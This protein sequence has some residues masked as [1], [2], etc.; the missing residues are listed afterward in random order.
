MT[1]VLNLHGHEVI[2]NKNKGK[3]VIEIDLG[4][5]T[6][7]CL[8]IDIFSVD[9][10]EYIA[11]L[12]GESSD[13][14]IFNYTDIYDSEDIDLSMIEDDDEMDEVYHLFSHYW[15]DEMIDDLI[16]EYNEEINQE[17]EEN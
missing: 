14:Y 13:I 2:F 6:D 11:L 7:E 5:S 15:T 4:D 1:E 9:Q 10:K 16:D 12:S 17:D 8:L 3:A